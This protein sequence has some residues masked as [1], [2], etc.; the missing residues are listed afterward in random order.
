MTPCVATA[1][2]AEKLLAE[3]LHATLQLLRLSSTPPTH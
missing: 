2:R 3:D 1:L